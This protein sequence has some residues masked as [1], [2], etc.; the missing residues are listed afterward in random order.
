MNMN[1]VTLS[2]SQ[3]KANHIERTVRDERERLL[4][5]IRQSVSSQDEAEDIV[6][7]VFYQFVIGYDDI[8]SIDQV[9]GWLFRVARNKII[10]AF[11]KKKPQAFSS[12]I[13]PTLD[14][15][16][17][18]LM[19]EDI[20]PDTNNLPEED[21]LREMVWSKIEET[22][23]KLPKNQREVFVWHEFEQKS[24]KDMEKLTGETINTLISRKRYAVLSL[25]ESLA[26]LY[27]EMF[28]N[29]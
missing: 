10:D 3:A 12:L 25:R 9:S 29:E 6:Q 26:D 4:N 21:L 27:K 11:R 14:G 18:P 2:M 17:E 1:A 23:E 19:L 24:F 13:M 16:D 28:N 22:L 5:F 15:D 20:L 7:D 8:R